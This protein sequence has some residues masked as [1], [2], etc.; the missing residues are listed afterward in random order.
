MQILF[1][2]E[3]QNAHAGAGIAAASGHSAPRLFNLRNEPLSGPGEEPLANRGDVP[4][5]ENCAAII[6][7]TCGAGFQPATR[8]CL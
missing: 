3:Q 6:S 7:E 8:N 5:T 4:L 2:G 1:L